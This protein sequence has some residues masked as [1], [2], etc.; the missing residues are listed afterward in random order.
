MVALEKDK[1]FETGGIGERGVTAGAIY[2]NEIAVYARVV[3]RGTYHDWAA[4]AILRE[5][6]HS[7]GHVKYCSSVVREQKD[8]GTERS[9]NMFPYSYFRRKITF[10]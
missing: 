8:F 5:L 3:S 9:T 4:I 2:P 10:P 1:K 7:N 6:W